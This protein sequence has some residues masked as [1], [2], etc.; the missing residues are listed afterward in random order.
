[1]PPLWPLQPAP[2]SLPRIFSQHPTAVATFF[3]RVHGDDIHSP[4]FQAHI[5]RV[6]GGF[7]MTISLLDDEATLNAELAHLAEQHKE[8]GISGEYFNVSSTINL[9]CS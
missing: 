9:P 2:L 1:M 4:E 6:F 8:R 3:S 5:A 7:D